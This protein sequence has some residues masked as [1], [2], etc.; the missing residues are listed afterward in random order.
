MIPS[1]RSKLKKIETQISK[2]VVFAGKE[3]AEERRRFFIQ[4]HQPP[5][6]AWMDMGM[7]NC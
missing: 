4:H 7:S 1:L 5:D 2:R 6:W 3:A